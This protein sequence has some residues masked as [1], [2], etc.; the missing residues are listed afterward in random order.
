MPESQIVRTYRELFAVR[1][2]RAIF[3]AQCLATGSASA[4]SLA[5]GT[6]TYASTR[7]PVLSGL[8]MFGGPLVRLAAS[9]FLLSASDLLRPR[10][11]LAGVTAITCLADLLQP[12][13]VCRGA[14][15]SSSWPCPGWQCPRPEALAWRSS[16]TACPPGAVRLRPVQSQHRGRRHADHRFRARAAPPAATCL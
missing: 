12:S 5:L 3:A 16:P 13:P 6:I 10:Q 11:A 8:A 14:C 1:E 9:W 7:N 4:G 15:G 2:F